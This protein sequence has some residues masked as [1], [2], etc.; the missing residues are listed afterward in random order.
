[1]LCVN[2][3]KG[4][5]AQPT[6]TGRFLKNRFLGDTM[7][8]SDAFPPR[9]LEGARALL[10]SQ[11]L[12]EYLKST[13]IRLDPDHYELAELI[14][15][16]R[17]RN[18]ISTREI[19]ERTQTSERDIRSLLEELRTVFRLPI[20]STKRIPSGFY[21]IRTKLE[22]TMAYRCYTSAARTVFKNV[23]RFIPEDLVPTQNVESPARISRPISGVAGTRRASK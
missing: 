6:K 8:I 18:P 13:R 5:S 14:F 12:D 4:K 23:Q 7:K 22:A 19:V 1:M 3:S 15:P 16:R 2:S 17:L 9:N 10:S 11:T 20:G 21:W